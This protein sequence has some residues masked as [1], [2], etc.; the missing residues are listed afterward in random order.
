MI[1]EIIH[2]IYKIDVTLPENPLKNLN[3]YVIKGSERN[4]IID[5]G[6]N[7]EECLSSLIEGIK[8]LNLD[9]DVTDLFITHLHA[10]HSGL[11]P[12]IISKSSKIYM[13]PIDKN[14]L[15]KLINDSSGYWTKLESRYMMEGFSEEEVI[16]SRQSNPAR[17]LIP[18]CS[19]GIVPVQQGSKLC[20]GGYEFVAVTTPGHT[21]GHT[22]LYCE[23][24]QLMFTG[25][26]V[27]FGITPNITLWM[28]LPN[29]LGSYIESLHKI[30]KYDVKLALVG[31][32]EITGEFEKR[33]DEILVHHKERLKDARLIISESPGIN[34]Y[35][36]A[37]KMKW[38]IRAKDWSDFPLAQ[39]WFAIGETIA[40]LKYLIE[41]KKIYIIEKDNIN[42]YYSY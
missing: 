20:Y 38:S 32:R 15:D 30:K 7:R 35:N 10:D 18:R 12:E 41:D 31:H 22:C 26:H 5:T 21:P 24:E 16:K 17:R 25:D 13:N 3:C 8:E 11:V 2:N 36:I 29:S 27:L 42:T 23:K 19:F 37:S 39:K 4:L 28:D 14:I 40:H 33:V 1:K 6:F 34:A 9:M